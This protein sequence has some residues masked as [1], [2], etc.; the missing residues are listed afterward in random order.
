MDMTLN[1]AEQKLAR[2]L[3][4]SRTSINRQAG[5]T[6]AKR[7]DLTD[8]E[9]DLDGVGAELAWCRLANV[10]PDLTLSPRSGGADATWAGRTVDVKTTRYVTGKL[11]AV[12]S[13]VHAPCDLYALM[14]GT[15]PTYRFV[16]LA[17]ADHLLAA[18]NIR[19]LGHGPTY[20]LEQDALTPP[21]VLHLSHGSS[22]T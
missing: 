1:A 5:V 6:N 10:Y 15:F 12:P 20:T 16:G 9:I 4:L 17:T 21:S 13:K 3:A 22:T 14:I 8:A 7:A 2:F 19:N 18:E 11:I